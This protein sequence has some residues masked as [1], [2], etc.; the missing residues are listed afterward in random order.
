MQGNQTIKPQAK[1]LQMQL[2][3][4]TTVGTDKRE[5]IGAS[6]QIESGE[7]WHREKILRGRD[8]AFAIVQLYLGPESLRYFP[9]DTKGSWSP[10]KHREIDH[11]NNVRQALGLDSKFSRTAANVHSMSKALRTSRSGLDSL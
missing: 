11:R 7:R 2:R 10:E 9:E 6:D 5:V 3:F 1:R 8:V 4:Q